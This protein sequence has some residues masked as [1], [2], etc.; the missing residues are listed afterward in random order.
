MQPDQRSL[1]FKKPQGLLEPPW[2][3]SQ[4][5]HSPHS[6]L[7]ILPHPGPCRCLFFS[8]NWS[9]SP[10][11]SLSV[12]LWVIHLRNIP[13]CAAGCAHSATAPRCP[14][15]YLCRETPNGDRPDP[16]P[17]VMSRRQTALRAT[18]ETFRNFTNW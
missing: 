1:L 6:L 5:S 17:P 14:H 3:L 8:V 11:S 15:P 18:C 9:E 13:C 7:E 10:G 2:G 16:S 4:P 12:T